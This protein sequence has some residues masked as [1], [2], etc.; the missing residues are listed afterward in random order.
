MTVVISAVC[1]FS[2]EIVIIP[3]SIVLT[4]TDDSRVVAK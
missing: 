1:Y 2:I 4:I 3:G